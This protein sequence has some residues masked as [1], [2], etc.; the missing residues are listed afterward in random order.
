MTIEKTIT[1]IFETK[2]NDFD[3][4]LMKK[5][6]LKYLGMDS[7]EFVNIIVSICKEMGINPTELDGNI[8][9]MENTFEE[10]LINF[11]SRTSK[12]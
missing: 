6:K 9:S 1:Q 2:L 5:E 3:A 11:N 7:I 4:E 12:E 10:F 8:I